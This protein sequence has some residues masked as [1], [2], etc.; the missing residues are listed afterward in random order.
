[1]FVG[2]FLVV[3]LGEGEPHTEYGDT[4]LWAVNANIAKGRGKKP[5]EHYFRVHPDVQDPTTAGSASSHHAICPVTFLQP[6]AKIS[7]SPKPSSFWV[8]GGSNK[9]SD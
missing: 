1:M 4:I 8:F 3:N 7:P 6:R 5:E 2:V 9:K